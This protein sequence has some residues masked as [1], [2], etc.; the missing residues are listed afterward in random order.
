MTKTP[1]EYTE[2]YMDGA[3]SLA[4]TR[5]R[6]GTWFFALMGVI[7]LFT[8][9]SGV[10]VAVTKGIGGAIVP[11][12]FSFPLTVMMTLLFSHVRVT[13]TNKELVVQYGLFG[14]KIP[15][16]HVT[17]ISAEDYN[18]KEFGGW[19]IK[20]GRDGTKAY[21]VSGPQIRCVRVHYLDENKKEQKVVVST[22]DPE[23]IVL[24]VQQSQ[25]GTSAEKTRIKLEENAVSSENN[26]STEEYAEEI[27]RASKEKRN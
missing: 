14:P 21:S 19:G 6:M 9:G 27:V 13:V 5:V 26:V 23:A 7:A 17:K 3:Q 15:L 18:W 24:A 1:D 20:Y 2:K 11:L 22:D 25:T 10:A 16:N 8:L 12:F 4:H